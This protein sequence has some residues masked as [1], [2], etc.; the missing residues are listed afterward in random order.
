M[1]EIGAAGFYIFNLVGYN[2]DD[3][4]KG[5]KI[6]ISRLIKKYGEGQIC[7]IA[8]QFIAEVP[9][10]TLPALLQRIKEKAD[11]LQIDSVEPIDVEYY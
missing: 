5:L 6:E 7:E 3:A 9:N 2:Y 11:H 4:N 1:D 8:D 10:A